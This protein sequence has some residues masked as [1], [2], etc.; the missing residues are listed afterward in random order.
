MDTNPFFLKVL[1]VVINLFHISDSVLT[2]SNAFPV[3]AAGLYV[4]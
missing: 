3:S 1:P 2:I 4:P